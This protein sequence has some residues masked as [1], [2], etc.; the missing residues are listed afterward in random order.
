LITGSSAEVTDPPP[1]VPVTSTQVPVAI[2]SRPDRFVIDAMPTTGPL[3]DRFGRVH[4]DLRISVTDRCNLRC[5]HCLPD[6]DVT[7]LPRD[8]LL[9]YDEL[10]RV[11]EVAHRLGIISV[12]VTGGE[13]LIRR[14]ITEFVAS[15][16]AIGFEDLSL[17][18]NG[19]EL[20]RLAPAL[21]AAG[22]HRVNVSCDSLQP[23]RF[24]RIRRRGEL[25][26]VLAS[27]DAAESAGLSP[28]KVNVVPI[29]G[30]NDDEMESF[31]AFARSTGRSVR[32][33]EFMPLDGDGRWRRDLV[34][35]ADEI[36]ARIHARW[37]LE[38]VPS[39]GLDASQPAERYRFID[40]NGEI[41]VIASVT[42]PFCGTCDRLRVT[43][44][45]S[46]RNCL[47]THDE[48]SVRTVLGDGG[49]DDDLAL[50]IRRAVWAKLPGH[51]INDPAY[52]Q[53]ERSMSMIGG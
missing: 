52:L 20:A 24:S 29:V 12:R 28:V 41:G 10:A 40:G 19:T 39:L 38:A 4:R 2:R 34:V 36:L 14:G 33:I 37:P 47:F 8:E 21:A 9:G 53:P 13:P 22:L 51:G 50:M 15:L 43:A 18:T 26:A 45:G 1:A 44:D 35:P 27:M 25:A 31:A 3:V 16:S 11:A 5:V 46:L 6:E 42:R 49:T 17:T 30:V 32:F 7:F 48:L 23:D